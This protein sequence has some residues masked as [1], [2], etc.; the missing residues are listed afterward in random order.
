MLL[1]QAYHPETSTPTASASTLHDV[2]RKEVTAYLQATAQELERERGVSDDP[3]NQ[4][5]R[6]PL[7]K[8]NITS[9]QPRQAD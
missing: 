4:L 2:K 5:A 9:F 3:R 8:K 1:Q 7:K 6:N